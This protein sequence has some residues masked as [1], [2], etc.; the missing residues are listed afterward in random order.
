MAQAQDDHDLRDEAQELDAEYGEEY[1][2]E[3]VEDPPELSAAA[4]ELALLTNTMKLTLR[5]RPLVEALLKM[6]KEWGR[7]HG[8]LMEPATMTRFVNKMKVLKSIPGGQ[9]CKQEQEAILVV[10]TKVVDLMADLAQHDALGTAEEQYEAREDVKVKRAEEKKQDKEKDALEKE[11]FRLKLK[12][13]KDAQKKERRREQ[14][15]VA[16]AKFKNKKRAADDDDED[17][18]DS[19][20]SKYRG[21]SSEDDNSNRGGGGYGDDDGGYGDDDGDDDGIRVSFK[22]RDPNEVQPLHPSLLQLQN[23]RLRFLLGRPRS[24]AIFKRVMKQA[25]THDWLSNVWDQ[26]TKP[27][28]IPELPHVRQRARSNPIRILMP[29][30]GASSAAGVSIE[31]P[32]IPRRP[33]SAPAGRDSTVRR[34]LTSSSTKSLKSRLAMLSVD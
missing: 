26:F 4:A 29:A 25:L 18:D 7:E 2:E 17:G 21:V 27:P 15:R 32:E 24:K 23:L 11:E 9:G 14:L 31:F 22:G 3:Y 20:G 6:Y 10:I 5:P 33:M 8:V 13:E 12:T 30:D 19:Q 34:E 28:H 16:Q 1:V